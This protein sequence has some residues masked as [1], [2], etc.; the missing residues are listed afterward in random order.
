M[1]GFDFFFKVQYYIFLFI[2]FFIW[3][4]KK[5]VKMNTTVKLITP[6]INFKDSEST[7]VL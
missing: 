5:A 4:T 2:F 7:L 3:S 1:H 6:K